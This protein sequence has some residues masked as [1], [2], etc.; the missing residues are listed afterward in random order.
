MIPLEILGVKSSNFLA[1]P[2]LGEISRLDWK[3]DRIFFD[4]ILR[5]AVQE[6]NER[7]RKALLSSK[8][9]YERMELLKQADK[10]IMGGLVKHIYRKLAKR[11]NAMRRITVVPD[12]N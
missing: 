12:E 11:R 3:S 10:V 8:K 6:K 5:L 1:F 9:R 4:E 7:L 2:S